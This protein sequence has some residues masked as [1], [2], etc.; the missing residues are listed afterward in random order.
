MKQYENILSFLQNKITK[1]TNLKEEKNYILFYKNNKKSYPHLISYSE[2][3][4]KDFIY[5][6]SSIGEKKWVELYQDFYLKYKALEY[7]N[8]S[9]KEYKSV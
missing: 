4:D 2:N 3:N 7:Y 1:T 9:R 8:L 6:I 5:Y